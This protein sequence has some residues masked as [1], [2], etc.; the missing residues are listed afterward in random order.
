MQ[1]QSTCC[2]WPLNP[3][4][5]CEVYSTYSSVRFKPHLL[6]SLILYKMVDSI[7]EVRSMLAAARSQVQPAYQ[8]C[9]R[10]MLGPCSEARMHLS[11]RIRRADWHPS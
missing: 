10:H 1:A 6:L 2:S 7:Q 8:F 11:C 3:Q 5:L 9:S 4:V